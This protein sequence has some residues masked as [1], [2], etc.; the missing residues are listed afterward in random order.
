[1]R[2]TSPVAV[3]T[4][5]RA[6]MPPLSATMAEIRTWLDSERIEPASF[7]TVVVRGGLGF[8]SASKAKRKQT[9]SDV[10]S[11]GSSALSARR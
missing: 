7:K 11:L 3:R 4:E 5:N 8:G 1:M 9:A 2:L 6:N 10:N